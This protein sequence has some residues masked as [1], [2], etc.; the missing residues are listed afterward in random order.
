MGA[1]CRSDFSYKKNLK[2]SPARPKGVEKE[3][4][5]IV[6]GPCG[7]HELGDFRELEKTLAIRQWVKGEIKV[8]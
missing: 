7:G 2:N 1:V 4:V 6:A 3:A 5:G 8:K